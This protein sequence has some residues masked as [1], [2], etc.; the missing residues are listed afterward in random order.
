MAFC[1]LSQR[2]NRE[3]VVAYLGNDNGSGSDREDDV[4]SRESCNRDADESDCETDAKRMRFS[5][6]E[7]GA[8]RRET[9]SDLADDD[10]ATLKDDEKLALYLLRR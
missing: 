9:F 5:D 6:I 2:S 7:E 3:E 1:L 10:G 8:E 4:E